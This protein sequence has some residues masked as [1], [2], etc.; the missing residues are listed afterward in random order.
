MVE[1][2]PPA[3]RPRWYCY[4]TPGFETPEE[5]VAWGLGHARTVIVRTLADRCYCAG[6][7]PTDWETRGEGAL[8]AW[9]PPRAERIEL[10]RERASAEEEASA[11]AAYEAA[12]QRW[13][14]DHQ[15]GL[16]RDPVTHECL[17]LASEDDATPI[18]L[19]ELDADGTLYGARRRR[20]SYAF[21]GVAEVIAA[22][23]TRTEGDPWVVAVCEALARERTWQGTGRRS[24]LLVIRGEGEMFHLSAAGN[25]DSIKRHGLD[26]RRMSAPGVAGSPRPEL[27]AIFL[28]AT[29]EDAQFFVQMARVPSDLWAVDVAGL[30]LEG[31]PGAD[32]GGGANWMTVAQPIE[33]GRLRLVKT[34]IPA[35]R[36]SSSGLESR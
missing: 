12:R 26:W 33:P 32:G 5:A 22:V 1:D 15:A 29:Q 10:E 9:P 19:E 14:L 36:G 27:P 16:A 7:H 31:D 34:N 30:W 13:L 20:G 18:E 35:L 6:E 23:S 24:M 2:P 8:R 3:T 21:G 25:R 28:C 11:R 17:L 4:G